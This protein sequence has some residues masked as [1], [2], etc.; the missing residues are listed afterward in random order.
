MRVS[1]RNPVKPPMNQGDDTS[2]VNVWLS[3]SLSATNEL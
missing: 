1:K 3:V 2:I